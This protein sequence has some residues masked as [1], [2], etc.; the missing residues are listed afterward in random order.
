[1]NAIAFVSPHLDDVALSC[2][3]RLLDAVD[4][5]QRVVV[6]TMFSEG[7]SAERR[8]REDRVALESVGADVEHLGLWDAPER[9]G[10]ARDLRSLSLDARVDGRDV[11][12][13]R[14][15]LSEALVRWT[16][17]C[18]WFPL[19]VGEHIDHRVAFA[20]H[21]IVE[22][23]R[24]YFDRPYAFV[25]AL[26]QLRL[27]KLGTGAEVRA[28]VR[29]EVGAQDTDLEPIAGFFR[30]ARQRDDFAG[31]LRGRLAEC[32][33]RPD[34]RVRIERTSWANAKRALRLIDGYGTQ[35]GVLSGT[36]RERERWTDGAQWTERS[37]IMM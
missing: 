36:A 32:A 11:A 4:R 34:G 24:F 37:C 14:E 15:R 5:R 13:A 28:E 22:S 23:P 30:S 35:R 9:L 6:I 8:K 10:I 12:S 29:A 20:C 27:A 33:V 17:G 16:P 19:G 3:G 26:V 25:D 18:V 2:A 21:D 31:A 7:R 1:M